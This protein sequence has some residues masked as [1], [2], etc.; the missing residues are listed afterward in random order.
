[1]SFALTKPRIFPP[2]ASTKSVLANNCLALFRGHLTG[3]IGGLWLQ[4]RIAQ[5]RVAARYGFHD[6]DT[7]ISIDLSRLLTARPSCGG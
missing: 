6:N 5:A 7:E 4:S 1:M 2:R 3:R